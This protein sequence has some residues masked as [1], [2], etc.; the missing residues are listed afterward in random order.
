MESGTADPDQGGMES[1]CFPVA[2][3]NTFLSSGSISDPF[4]EPKLN[5]K[6]QL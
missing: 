4:M 2:L 6:F 5:G 3:Q 1:K